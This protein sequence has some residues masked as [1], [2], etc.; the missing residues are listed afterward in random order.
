MRHV[1][2]ASPDCL[3]LLPAVEGPR[4]TG[5]TVAPSIGCLHGH[6]FWPS[7]PPCCWHRICRPVA[8]PEVGLP[9]L[10]LLHSS[11]FYWWRWRGRVS[12][13]TNLK[14]Q[15]N[16][17]IDTPFRVLLRD[18]PSLPAGGRTRSSRT[19]AG[20]TSQRRPQRPL[21]SDSRL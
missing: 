17:V 9:E 10:D 19:T 18:P 8:P 3:F 4:Q 1:R 6:D 20:E 13:A 5:P 15:R 14:L 21:A 2:L 16:M 11:L 7:P 12:L